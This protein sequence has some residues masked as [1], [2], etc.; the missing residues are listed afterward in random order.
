MDI[1]SFIKARLQAIENACVK[2]D[3]VP[4]LLIKG[5]KQVFLPFDVDGSPMEVGKLVP[6]ESVEIDFKVFNS[7]FLVQNGSVNPIKTY[8]SDVANVL[9]ALT[10]DDVFNLLNPA[11]A[12]QKNE[13]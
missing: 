12:E 10:T 4:E 9:N 6:A 13:E 1:K 8:R 3:S 7:G 11:P 5:V 2:G